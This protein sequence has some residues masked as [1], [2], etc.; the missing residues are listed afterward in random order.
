MKQLRTG[1][2]RIRRIAR[3]LN[4]RVTRVR[5]KIMNKLY[6]FFTLGI[7]LIF[8]ILSFNVQAEPQKTPEP[9]AGVSWEQLTDQQ[10][11]VLSDYESQWSSFPAA[12][13]VILSRGAKQWASMNGDQR[14]QARKRFQKWQELPSGKR[15]ELKAKFQNDALSMK[16]Y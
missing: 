11:A 3:A 4:S 7:A 2:Y 8:L 10:R 15:Q 1:N 16:K 12:S 9:S 14:A 5:C 13:Q 6:T